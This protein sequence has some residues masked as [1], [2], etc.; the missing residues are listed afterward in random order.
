MRPVTVVHELAE[1]LLE[2][3][4]TWYDTEGL[5]LPERRYVSAGAPPWDCELVAVWCSGS[6]PHQGDINSNQ[7]TSLVGHAGSMLRWADLNVTICRCAPVV[8]E[9]NGRV[10]FPSV[11]AEQAIAATIHQD[12]VAVTTAVKAGAEGGILPDLNDWSLAEWKVLGPAGG[13]V[14]SEHRLRVSTSWRP[15]TGS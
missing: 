6:G 8:S 5:A 1:R 10:I 11:D 9:L 12:E 3:V 7:A 4:G 14:A 13:F 2:A 15:P